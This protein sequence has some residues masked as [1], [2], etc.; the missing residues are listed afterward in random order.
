MFG[1]RRTAVI[2]TISRA[3]APARHSGGILGVAA[4]TS[5]VDALRQSYPRK[6]NSGTLDQIPPPRPY[7]VIYEAPI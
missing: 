6:R 4:Q 5:D 2:S 3:V 7:Q 1:G